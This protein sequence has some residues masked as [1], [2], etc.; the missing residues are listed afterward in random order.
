MT[1]I[2]TRKVD[3]NTKEVLVAENSRKKFHERVMAII[4]AHPDWDIETDFI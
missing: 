1:W 3:E 4:K 2:A